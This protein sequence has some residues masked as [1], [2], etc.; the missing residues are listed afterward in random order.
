MPPVRSIRSLVSWTAATPTPQSA[1]AIAMA[2]VRARVTAHVTVARPAVRLPRVNWLL[3]T[4][5]TVALWAGWSFLGK[6]AL[7]HTTAVQATVVFGFVAMLVG[8]AAI[9]AGQRTAAWSFSTLWLAALSALSGSAGLITFYFALQQ[10]RASVVVP[11]IGLYPAIV[12]LLSV[13]LL[14]ERL[15]AVQYVG[16]LLAVTGVVLLGAG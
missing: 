2:Y 10:G 8:F 11:I 5:V 16:I 1:A 14:G 9:A 13:L 6:L 3:Y 12:A 7:E 15:S 4:L